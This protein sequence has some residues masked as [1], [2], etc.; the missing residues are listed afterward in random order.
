MMIKEEKKILLKPKDAAEMLGV[1]TKTIDNWSKEKQL[2]R[3][4]IAIVTGDTITDILQENGARI[5]IMTSE[6]F[7]S[8]TRSGVYRDLLKQVVCIV[9]DEA[10]LLGDKN[11]GSAIEMSIMRMARINKKAR[12]ILLSA[13]LSNA[14]EVAKWLKTLNGKPTKSIKSNWRPVKINIKYFPVE[15]KID[16]VNKAVELAKELQWFK[17]IVF[18]NSKVT[19]AEIVK[20]LR[21]ERIRAMF[22]NASLPKGKRPG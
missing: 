5:I 15:G 1:T 18:V 12:F 21:A 22:H 2:N 9:Y 14:T 17:T 3:Y 4:G 13:T 19:G 20:K 16:K 11:R 10:H 7:D 6:S 8:R